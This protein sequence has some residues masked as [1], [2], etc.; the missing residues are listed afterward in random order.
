M[1]FKSIHHVNLSDYDVLTSN[2]DHGVTNQSLPAL[3]DLDRVEDTQF[4][5]ESGVF[6]RATLAQTPP[7]SHQLLKS[8]R[9]YNTPL[10]SVEVAA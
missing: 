9:V 3:I 4:R 10:R 7:P 6:G 1:H 8:Y 2:L 5:R